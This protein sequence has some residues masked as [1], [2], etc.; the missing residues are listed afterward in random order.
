[1]LHDGIVGVGNKVV[2]EE[3]VVATLT[4]GGVVGGADYWHLFSTLTNFN[5]NQFQP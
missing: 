2:V 1:M 4:H 5:L 3:K